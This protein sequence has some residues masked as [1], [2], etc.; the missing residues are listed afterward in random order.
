MTKSVEYIIVGDGYAAMFLAHQ[1][2]KNN[3]IIFYFYRRQKSASMVSAGMINPAV[4]K[5]FTTFWLAQE[6]IDSLKN[7]MT[8]INNIQVKIT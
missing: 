1:F 3:K 4:L 2:I 8:E 6:Q 5:R 7:T